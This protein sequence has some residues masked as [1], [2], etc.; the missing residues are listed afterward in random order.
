MTNCHQGFS[1]ALTYDSLRGR[2]RS[3]LVPRGLLLKNRVVSGCV[4][5][6]ADG[7]AEVLRVDP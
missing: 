4:R 6:G 3:V 1:L 5:P 7:V 2:V